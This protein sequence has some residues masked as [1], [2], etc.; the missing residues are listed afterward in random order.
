MD[1]FLLES[2]LL[3]SVALFYELGEGSWPIKGEDD[4]ALR[5]GNG[6]ALVQATVEEAEEMSFIA[7]L[8]QHHMELRCHID[9]DIGEA[10]LRIR[11]S[12]DESFWV[13]FVY[14]SF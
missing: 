11:E 2:L 3:P 8:S 4:A 10:F 14:P 5:V 6:K 9:V 12:F 13:A 1:T 7:C